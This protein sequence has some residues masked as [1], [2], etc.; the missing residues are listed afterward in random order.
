MEDLE[1]VVDTIMQ[2]TILVKGK[3]EAEL[4][5]N[6]KV[7]S[8]FIEQNMNDGYTQINVRKHTL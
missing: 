6:I 3:D 7:V 1:C 8:D 5:E 4:D 2:N